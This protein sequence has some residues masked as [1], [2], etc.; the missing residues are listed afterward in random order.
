MC[1][2]LLRINQKIAGFKLIINA[3][4]Y[5][6]SES[7]GFDQLEKN[8]RKL[9]PQDQVSV[10]VGHSCLVFCLGKFLT[11]YLIFPRKMTT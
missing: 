7:V 11:H 9:F 4:H 6:S 5:V 10:S 1:R 8:E 2:L 3:L